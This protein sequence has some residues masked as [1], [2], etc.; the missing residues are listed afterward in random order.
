MN[1]GDLDAEG[2]RRSPA[3]P[4][5]ASR[6]KERP[7]RVPDVRVLVAGDG[8]ETRGH[9]AM[10]VERL[11]C[12]VVEFREWQD[13]VQCLRETA[14]NSREQA[15][16]VLLLDLRMSGRR[17]LDRVREVTGDDVPLVVVAGEDLELPEVSGWTV[18]RAPVHAE[19]VRQAIVSCTVQNGRTG[20]SP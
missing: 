8:R 3:Q 19:T 15:D 12:E 14:P 1:L 9:L 2:L 6:A 20:G 13:L 17:L 5:L 18:L 11:G 10:A 4:N 7:N 16:A